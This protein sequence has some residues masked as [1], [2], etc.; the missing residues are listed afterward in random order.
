MRNDAKVRAASVGIEELELRLMPSSVPLLQQTFDASPTGSLPSGWSQWSSSGSRSFEV[1]S[2][3]ALAGPNGLASSG[4]SNVAARAWAATWEPADVQ[5]SAAVFVD[6]LTPAQLLVRGSNLNSATPSYYALSVGRGMYVQLVRVVNGAGAV[7][8]EVDT[9]SY[10]EAKWV[11]LTLSATG[12]RLQAQIYRPDTGQYLNSSG[13]W[14]SAPTWALERTD[15]AISTGGYTGLAR[16]AGYSGTVAFDSFSVTGS[17]TGSPAGPTETF[18]GTRPGSLPSGWAQW[19]SGAASFAVSTARPEDGAAGL[20]SSGASSVA[21][22]GWLTTSQ[23]A[24]V[25]ASAAVFVNGLTPAQVL[26]RGSNLNSANPTYYALTVRQGLYLQLVRVINGRSTPLIDLSSASWF[27]G[28]WVQLTLSANGGQLQAQVYRPDTRQYLNSS[29]RWQSAQTNALST[30]D[31]AISGAGF[32]GVGRVA[33]YAGNVYFD[34]FSTTPLASSSTGSGG[35]SG[36]SGSTQPGA[37]AIP[38]H[39]D[40][41]RIAQLAYSG[42]PLGAYEDQLLRNSVDLVITDTPGLTQH[43]GSVSPGTPQL[44]YINFTSLYGNLLT[45]WLAWA[46]AHGVSREA[47]F[48]H[49]TRGTAFSGDSPSSQPVTWFWA[50]YQGGTTPTFQDETEAAHIAG[51]NDFN[52]GGYGASTYIAYPEQFSQI[53]FRLESGAAA[54]WSA[55]LEYP[56]AVDSFGNPTAWAT[57]PTTSN[58]TLG[59]SRSGQIDFN[60]PSNWKTASL[61]GSALMYY[62]RVRVVSDGRAPVV[63]TILGADYVHADG[64]TYG[65][66]P[67]QGTTQF[68]YQSRL[69]YGIYGQM[70]FE[71]NPS[72]PFFR[73]WAI[74]YTTRYLAA[75]PRLSGLFVDNSAGSP[76]VSQGVVA[77]SIASYTN[78]YGSLLKAVGQAI[79]PHWLLA[80]TAGGGLTAD[81][82]VSQNVAYF[83]E[84]S[85]RPLAASYQQFENTAALIAHR[86][87]LQTPPPY[88]VLDALPTGGSATDPRTQIAALA[89][90]YLLADP[91]R[92]FLDPF[93]G[94]APASSWTQH[95]FGAITYN[96]GQPQGVWS[97]FASGADPNNLSFAYRVYARRY[98]NAL[99][100]YKPLSS[101]LNG[102]AVGSAGN[103]T[104]TTHALGGSYRVLQA[105]GTLGP[106]VTSIT[107][108]NGEGAIL[109]KT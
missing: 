15:S 68:A 95:F 104:A 1:S 41:I 45:D 101:T 27:A 78:D 69:F 62:V 17:V 50:V 105:N 58:S 60:P 109:I 10:F 12:N 46:D 64:R 21:A 44:A 63:S 89:E 96:V 100:L 48:L 14:Q 66:I 5:A 106:V 71:T 6:G 16:A 67:A 57:L 92:T 39:Y 86:A 97:V 30:T 8:G 61:N 53:N 91:H 29:G 79:A 70:R 49:V 11:Q 42:T 90:Y 93:G 26:L 51:E 34:N 98:T 32:A 99:V 28:N 33:G 81:P 18:D 83:E 37:P 9:A 103:G 38:Q 82:V 4:A 7:L 31:S 40:W 84:S 94:S 87:S 75:H 73:Q 102:S 2:A 22:R 85:L 54:G 25:Q 77:E 55:V 35:G 20:A 108:R 74:D 47:A 13:R 43:I 80:N 52:L 23:P 88:A 24:N 19:S 76:L 3:R 72:N 107:L 59:F 65:I 36:G 56:T